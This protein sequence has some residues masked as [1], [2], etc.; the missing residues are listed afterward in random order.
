MREIYFSVDVETNGP[1]PADFSMLSF[2]AAAYNDDGTFLDTFERNLEDLDGAKEDADTMAWW[3]TQ[4][5]AWELCQK[6]KVNPFDA[7]T[8]FTKWIDDTCERFNGKAVFL[9]YPAGFDFTFIY[10][11][12]M[13]F[14][15]R[16]PFSFNSLDIKSYGM[17]M[18]G[19]PFK[20]TTKRAFPNRW[21]SKRR[22]TH[23][24]IEDAL[25]QGELFVAMLKE[26]KANIEALKAVREAVSKL[27]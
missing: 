18:L 26:N 20:E 13:H 10:W 8:D 21:K 6:N 19:T 7:M 14:T 11:Y 24:A 27:R 15:G 16:C 4:P 3:A 22:H 1:I 12:F 2:G 23:E 17:A 9:A 25:G 5:E